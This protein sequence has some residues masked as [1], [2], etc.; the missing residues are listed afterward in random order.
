[1]IEL[2]RRSFPPR[3]HVLN[4]VDCDCTH[5]ESTQVGLVPRA[6][7]RVL[8]PIMKQS[9][10]HPGSPEL[11][12]LLDFL[13]CLL[14]RDVFAATRF[15]HARKE[16]VCT[17]SAAAKNDR[18]QLLCGLSPKCVRSSEGIKAEDVSCCSQMA[19][20]CPLYNC[21]SNG[22]TNGRKGSARKIAQNSC[23][24]CLQLNPFANK[25]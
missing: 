19:V 22:S 17:P 21:F 5:V 10:Q 18:T 2:I 9:Q 8:H 3:R 4:I 14:Y 1:M 13:G 25:V 23:R 11:L 7:R 6:F 20:L 12:R 15:R 16:I 24:K